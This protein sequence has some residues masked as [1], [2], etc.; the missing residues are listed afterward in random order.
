MNAQVFERIAGTFCLLALGGSATYFAWDS[1]QTQVVARASLAASQKDAD[2]LVDALVRPCGGGKPCGTLATLSKAITKA[3]DAVVTTQ[4]AERATVP[5]VL[6]AMDSFKLA[7]DQASQTADA[8]TGTAR[9]A[10][11]TLTTAQTTIAAGKP[12]LESLTRTGDASTL[13]VEHF[14][15]LVQAKDWTEALH[16]VNGIS[17]NVEGITGSMDKISAHLEKTVDAKKPLWQT[18]IPG[19]ELGGKL[20]ACAWYHVCVD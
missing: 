12:L 17:A 13:A 16:H 18:L 1:H 2:S 11:G 15:A 3:G 7:G 19:A 6:A 10:T 14:D 5:H 4:L 8:L 20:W 9:A